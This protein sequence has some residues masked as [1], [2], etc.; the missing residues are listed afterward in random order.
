LRFDLMQRNKLLITQ[1]HVRRRVQLFHSI[2][3]CFRDFG[4]GVIKLLRSFDGIWRI[5]DGKW[6][7]R[8]KLSCWWEMLMFIE[9]VAWFEVECRIH[10]KIWGISLDWR[11][12][13][14][15]LY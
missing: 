13:R 1:S 10:G 6:K 3:V 5:L 7:I 14:K 12:K 4:R 11:K 8:E 15:K 2:F 9:I